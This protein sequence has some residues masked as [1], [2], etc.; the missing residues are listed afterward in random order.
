MMVPVAMR[1]SAVSIV[2]VALAMAGFVV[3]MVGVTVHASLTALD[4]GA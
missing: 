4:R 2:L 1:A 3:S